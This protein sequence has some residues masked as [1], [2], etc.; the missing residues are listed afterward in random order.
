[1]VAPLTASPEAFC[2]SNFT[3]SPSFSVSASR[4][5]RVASS[6]A[7]CCSSWQIPISYVFSSAMAAAAHSVIHRASINATIFFIGVSSFNPTRTVPRAS[8]SAS[9]SHPSPHVNHGQN[10][11]QKEYK[12]GNVKGMRGRRLLCKKPLPRAPSRRTDGLGDSGGEAASL[13]EAPLPQ[14]PSPEERL[15]IGLFSLLEVRAHESWA[16]VPAVWLWSRRLTEP[17]R[18]ANNRPCIGK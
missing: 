12:E 10:K 14:A 1:M 15:G 7:G 9:L 11:A 16:R 2:S 4:K 17:P 13:R 5:P 3:L 6:S 8:T 18:P